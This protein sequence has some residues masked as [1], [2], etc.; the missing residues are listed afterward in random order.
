MLKKGAIGILVLLAAGRPADAN[1]DPRSATE[2]L[3]A[4]NKNR[5]SLSL[6]PLRWSERLSDTAQHWADHLVAIKRL[7]HSGSG[8]NLATATSGTY[9]LTQLIDLW[10]SERA[11]FVDG[12]FPAIS[13]TRNWMDAGHYS[14]IVWRMTTELGC[15]FARGGG[16][17]VL[18]CNYSPP[19]NVVGER[20]Y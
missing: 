16:M 8:Q 10:G 5:T 20:P 13:T 9:S 4:H 11:Q 14:Q 12:Y 2:L 17:D 18:V 7:E 6:A 15:G 19:G 3:E 1:L